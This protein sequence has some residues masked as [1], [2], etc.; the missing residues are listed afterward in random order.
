LVERDR[1]RRQPATEE[2]PRLPLPE[3]P[4]R[5]WDDEEES[6]AGEPQ[7]GVIIIPIMEPD[8]E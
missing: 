1:R 8:N 3:P 5:R 7:R 4:G 6:S 2:R